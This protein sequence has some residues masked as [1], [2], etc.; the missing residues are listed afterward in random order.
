MHETAVLAGQLGR[1]PRDKTVSFPKLDIAT[2]HGL[3]CPSGGLLIVSALDIFVTPKVIV[4]T[5]GVDAIPGHAAPCRSRECCSSTTDAW[6]E[7][8]PVMVTIKASDYML[9]TGR[10]NRIGTNTRRSMPAQAWLA[11]LQ[12]EDFSS[13]SRAVCA[14]MLWTS[15]SRRVGCRSRE[16]NWLWHLASRTVLLHEGQYL[17][18]GHRGTLVMN[19][20]SDCGEYA[21]CLDDQLTL[22]SARMILCPPGIFCPSTSARFRHKIQDCGST[23][24]RPPHSTF[25]SPATLVHP[26]KAAMT[27]TSDRVAWRINT[28][29]SNQKQFTL[30]RQISDKER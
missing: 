18:R 6:L 15:R 7:P 11:R 20:G 27:V 21:Q 23:P 12:R 4:A 29:S 2:I 22:D 16:L 1:R 30:F 14:S 8:L 13:Y 17:C 3:L 19:S 9:A 26:A 10:A 24:R 25:S 5:D 28:N